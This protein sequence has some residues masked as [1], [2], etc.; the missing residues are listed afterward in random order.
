M[1]DGGLRRHGNKLAACGTVRSL[2][3]ADPREPPRTVAIDFDHA[4]N[5]GTGG[6]KTDGVGG[7]IVDRHQRIRSTGSHGHGLV[8]SVVEAEV[9]TTGGCGRQR[10]DNRTGSS[11]GREQRTA[12]V[13]LDRVI[14][15]LG[16]DHAEATTKWRAPAHQSGSSHVFLHQEASQL[17]LLP[18][19][20]FVGVTRN[21][22][23][24]IATNQQAVRTNHTAN[25]DVPTEPILVAAASLHLHT[26]IVQDAEDELAAIGSRWRPFLQLARAVDLSQQQTGPQ[27]ISNRVTAVPCRSVDP[28]TGKHVERMRTEVER[29]LGCLDQITDER[30]TLRL[31]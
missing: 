19:Q 21:T 4:T 7:Q 6:G 12:F 28:A 20:V 23:A 17:K 31:S 16:L 22:K 10:E 26:R 30:S 15:S 3:W 8:G 25:H 2:P 9:Q 27:N 1:N 11:T 24:G 14:G 13:R 18:D 5:L 29:I